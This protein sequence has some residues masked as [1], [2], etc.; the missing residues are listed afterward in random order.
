MTTQAAPPSAVAGGCDDPAGLHDHLEHAGT[1]ATVVYLGVNYIN[2]TWF[3]LAAAL[4][5]GLIGIVT[6]S[7][8]TTAATLG[9]SFVGMA[10]AI[11]AGKL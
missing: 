2:P 5:T 1:I 11:G 6:G 8:W 9:L 3:Y 10:T 4:L 7:S